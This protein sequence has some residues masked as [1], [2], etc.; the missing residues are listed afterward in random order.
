VTI[1]LIRKSLATLIREAAAAQPART[2]EHRYSEDGR[3]GYV[4]DGVWM[5][6]GEIAKAL[7]V[8]WP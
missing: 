4:L 2:L 1:E 3:N 7:G 5:T 6:P 8:V